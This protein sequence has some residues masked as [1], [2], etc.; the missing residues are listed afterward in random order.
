[1]TYAC[2]K[3]TDLTSTELT[4]SGQGKTGSRTDLMK[5]LCIGNS[6]SFA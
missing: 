3:V 5:L 4:H 2:V 6:R 1:M